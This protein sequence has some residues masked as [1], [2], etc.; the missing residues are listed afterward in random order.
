MIKFRLIYVSYTTKLHNC[1]LRI[2]R[3][4]DLKVFDAGLSH[5]PVEIENI[6]LRLFVPVW[7]PIVVDSNV[8]QISLVKVSQQRLRSFST[9]RIS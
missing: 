8:R 9:V 5:S 4:G 3:F 2:V 1:R 6:R 7:L